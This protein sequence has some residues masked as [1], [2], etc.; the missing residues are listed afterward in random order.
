MCKIFSRHLVDN[1]R[2][3]YNTITNVWALFIDLIELYVRGMSAM[4][5]RS[6]VW[7]NSMETAEYAKSIRIIIN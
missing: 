1:K 6:D 5:G 7:F 3:E 4:P 2:F